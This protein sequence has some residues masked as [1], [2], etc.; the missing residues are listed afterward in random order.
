[1][2]SFFLGAFTVS[3]S[4]AFAQ[5]IKNTDQA[6]GIKNTDKCDSRLGCTSS[7]TVFKLGIK[8]NNPLKVNTIQDAIKFFLNTIMK[9]A[10]PF[11][12]VFFIWSGLSFILARGNPEGIKK[13]KN[14]FLYT[15]IGTL[16]ILGAWAITNAIIGT[17]NTITS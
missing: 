17:V 7:A 4:V 11:I 1:M 9:I 16:L 13:A 6:P 5:G 14:M 3:H 2:L 10:L 8:L 12:V 15:I